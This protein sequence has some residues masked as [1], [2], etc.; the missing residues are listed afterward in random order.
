MSMTILKQEFRMSRRSVI[1]WCIALAAVIIIFGS[2]FSS[3]TKDAALLDQLLANYP[4]QLLEAF[5]MNNLDLSSIAGFFSFPFLFA[6]VCLAIQAAY[7]GFSLVSVEEREWTADFLLTK[8]LTR[9]QILTSKLLAALV[10]LT[11]TNAVVWICSFV[12]IMAFRGDKPFDAVP[13]LLLLLSVVVFQ[14]FFVA[15]GLVISLLVRRVRSVI[16]YAM[17]LA[18]GMYVLNAFGDMLGTSVLE[19]ITPFKHFDPRYILSHGAYNGPLALF[20]IV[21][22]V[23]CL[24]ASYR[25]YTRRD[26]PAVA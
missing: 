26:I 19:D 11:I 17:A 13:F 12:A 1:A 3:F 5:G 24:A 18:L 14:M 25:L 2:L 15:V 23:V 22:I 21:V 6:Q 4:P 20:S 16:S 9:S 10:G 7:Y 8:P